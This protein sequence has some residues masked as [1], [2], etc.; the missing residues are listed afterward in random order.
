MGW[1]GLKLEDKPTNGYVNYIDVG[2]RLRR[3]FWGQ[4]IAT[5]SAIASLNYGFE[6]LNYDVIYGAAEVENIGSNRVL[7]KIGLSFKEEFDYE[8]T[9]CN[10][11]GL[12][13]SEWLENLDNTNKFAFLF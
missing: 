13:K 4:G 10:W 1:S 5:E 8:G 9:P 12:K 2:Y 6:I 3:E 7:K 11:Y